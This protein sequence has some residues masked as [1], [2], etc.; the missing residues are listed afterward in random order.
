MTSWAGWWTLDSAV[1]WVLG[2]AWRKSIQVTSVKSIRSEEKEIKYRVQ[3]VQA[4]QNRERGL[5]KNMSFFMLDSWGDFGDANLNNKQVLYGNPSSSMMLTTGALTEH[6]LNPIGGTAL[7]AHSK[8]PPTVNTAFTKQSHS[9]TGERFD[10]P[11]TF[12]NTRRR[13]CMPTI[14][15]PLVAK[16]KRQDSHDI[17]PV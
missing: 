2:Q 9:L 11:I 13:Q 1:V 8:I 15:N 17:T 4:G 10:R 6:S 16:Q 5:Y 12:A 14:I 7:S 3:V